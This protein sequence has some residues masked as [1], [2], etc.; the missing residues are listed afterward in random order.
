MVRLA[1]RCFT[2]RLIERPWLKKGLRR[3]C[4]MSEASQQGSA[5]RLS[6]IRGKASIHVGARGV[7]CVTV[8]VS[9]AKS[10]R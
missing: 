1:K 3:S 10:R 7:A 8:W 6:A 9:K 2:S 5:G 4:G